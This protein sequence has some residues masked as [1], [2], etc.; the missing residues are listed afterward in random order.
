MHHFARRVLPQVIDSA[1][2]SG[3][4]G[5]T[6]TRLNLPRSA[7]A[8]PASLFAPADHRCQKSTAAVPLRLPVHSRREIAGE[9][10]GC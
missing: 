5:H 10:C 4:R 3:Q 9:K 7:I 8:L 1:R 6:A 2:M